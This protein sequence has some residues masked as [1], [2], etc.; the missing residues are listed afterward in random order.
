[1]TFCEVVKVMSFAS[2]V[3]NVLEGPTRMKLKY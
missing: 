2:K 3:V 1:M